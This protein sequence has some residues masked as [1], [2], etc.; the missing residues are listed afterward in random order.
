[1]AQSRLSYLLARGEPDLSGPAP[2]AIW[3]PRAGQDL[4]PLSAGQCRILTRFFPDHAWFSAH[5]HVCHSDP[6]DRYRAS[7]V[8]IPRARDAARDLIAR[9]AAVTD[10]PVIVDGAKTDGI[11][12]LYKD[13]RRLFAVSEAVSKAHGKAFW[14]DAAPAR[15][16]LSAWHAAPAT[17]PEGYHVQPGVFS[18]DGVDPG[19]ALLAAALPERLGAHVVDLGAGWGYLSA[20]ALGARPDIACLDLVEADLT[21][22]D[23]ARRNVTDPRARF[24]WADAT[25]WRPGAAADC[26]IMNPP[27]HSGRDTDPGLGQD[28]VRA[29]ASCLKP[30]GS[31]WLVANRHLPYDK[32]LATLFR[33]VQEMPGDTRF[34]ILHASRPAR[35]RG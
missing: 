5:G 8:C 18:A 19:S 24:H 28:F 1:M 29:A 12:S 4:S 26:V 25:H 16:A 34:K 33:N 23:C 27:F 9:A 31:L 30:T 14:F 35:P 3:S 17:T 32:L 22:L 21:A 11:E 10:G 20:Q 2:V 15:V 13:C 6:Q 7:V